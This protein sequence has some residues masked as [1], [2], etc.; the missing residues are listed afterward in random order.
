MMRLHIYRMCHA[1][2]SPYC[3]VYALSFS[4]EVKR[5]A[6]AGEISWLVLLSHFNDRGS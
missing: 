1:S 2:F 4:E 6:Y 3:C 5:A